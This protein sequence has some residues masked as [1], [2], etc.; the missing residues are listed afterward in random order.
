MEDFPLSEYLIGLQNLVGSANGVDAETKSFL[1]LIRRA[2]DKRRDYQTRWEQAFKFSPIGI[3][4]I[5]LDGFFKEVNPSACDLFE[6]EEE[7]LLNLRWQDITHPKDLEADENFVKSITQDEI[8]SYQMKKRYIM[9]DGNTKWALLTVSKVYHSSG[10]EYFI[11]Q[12]LDLEWLEL[13]SGWR[14][15]AR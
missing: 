15:D 14:N 11:S 6:R 1:P 5:D 12:V 3:C 10:V 4:I 9:P 8:T 7:E 2:V 13:L